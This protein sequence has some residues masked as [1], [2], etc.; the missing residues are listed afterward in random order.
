MSTDRAYDRNQYPK[1][2]ATSFI[3]DK[4]EEWTRY[5]RNNVDDRVDEISIFWAKAVFL[6]E[7]YPSIRIE[8]NISI[9]IIDLRHKWQLTL[10]F[11]VQ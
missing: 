5:S 1:Y 3:D 6:H 11:Q 7:K 8:E 2:I 10:T 4:T 9:R